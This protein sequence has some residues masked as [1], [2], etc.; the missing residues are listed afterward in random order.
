M[1]SQKLTNNTSPRLTDKAARVVFICVAILFIPFFS[2]FEGLAQSPEASF[3]ATPKS[4]C[5]PLIVEFT[6]Y[7]SGAASSIVEWVVNYGD[8]TANIDTFNT[9]PLTWTHEYQFQAVYSTVLKVTDALGNF[10]Y[11]TLTISVSES[12]GITSIELVNPQTSYCVNEVVEFQFKPT[13][14]TADEIRWVFGDGETLITTDNPVSHKYKTNGNYTTTLYASLGGCVDTLKQAVNILG[15]ESS[16]KMSGYEGCVNDSI[17]FTAGTSIGVDTYRWYPEGEGGPSF[18]SASP[19]TYTYPSWDVYEPYLLV[20]GTDGSCVLRDTT[21]E[22]FHVEASIGYKGDVEYCEGR[23]IYFNNLSTGNAFNEWDLGN[24]ELSDKVDPTVAYDAGSYVVELRI[25]N[26]YGCV[27]T[28]TEQISINNIPEITIGPDT[29]ICVGDSA[30]IWVS[31]GHT[32]EWKPKAGIGSPYSYITNTSPDKTTIYEPIVKDTITNCSSVQGS[33]TLV[34]SVIEVPELVF[35]VIIPDTIIIGDTVYIEI[36][37]NPNFNYLW[38]P[39]QNISCTECANPY[40]QPLISGENEYVLVVNDI[41]GC[42]TQDTVIGIFVHEEYTFGLPA[43]FTPTSDGSYDPNGVN[44]VIKVDGWGI[45]ELVEFSVF[46]R[47]GKKVFTSQDINIG[48]DGTFEGEPQAVGTYTY[49]IK[50]I[51]WDDVSAEKRGA[52]SLYR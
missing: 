26:E 50:I 51:Q 25:E 29:T 7:S 4:G 5:E 42:S 46:D 33:D 3:N 13:N 39:D 6:D 38:S 31:G 44:D 34:V 23:F 2:A 24:G 40:I 15:P 48:W 30:R 45:K 49:Y 27:D 1:P 9:A 18:V 28:T 52:F 32:V 8:G 14:V 19:F 11:D 43:A 21:V 17:T 47:W 37:S 22:I 35:N 41:Y 12:P 10:D 36:D 16:L 20:E